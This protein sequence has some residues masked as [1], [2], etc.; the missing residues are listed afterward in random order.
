[1]WK[2]TNQNLSKISRGSQ[3]VAGRGTRENQ[4]RSLREG[5]S[6][7]P[8][9]C[10]AGWVPGKQPC[11]DLGVVGLLQMAALQ[12]PFYGD[13]MNLYSLCKK[14]EQCD[15]PPLPSDHYSE[16]VSAQPPAVCPSVP[17]SV[18]THACCPR[19]APV[20]AAEAAPIAVLFPG[21]SCLSRS[22]I[23]WVETR[24]LGL[25]R[26]PPEE[27]GS[28]PGCWSRVR[29]SPC[30]QGPVHGAALPSLTSELSFQQP[31]LSSS[32]EPPPVMS[33][34]NRNGR[35]SA[36]CTSASCRPPP[37]APALSR[38]WPHAG[39]HGQVPGSRCGTEER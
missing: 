5:L 18:R 21:D 35:L 14:I 10:S 4:A 37:P 3:T 30:P 26:D 7:C 36:A 2:T 33:S 29:V 24:P 9:L 28:G 39:S 12:S 27:S 20:Q 32:A 22:A 25:R 17:P 23:L 38:L 15:Y 34:Q 6:P 16:E 13:K 11:D 19:D 31:E 1:M 8:T